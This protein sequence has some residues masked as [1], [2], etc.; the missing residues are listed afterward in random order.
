MSDEVEKRIEAAA[1]SAQ[2][3]KDTAEFL[4]SLKPGD[5]LMKSR[6]NPEAWIMR[7]KAQAAAVRGDIPTYECPHPV[8]YLRQFVD[9]DPTVGRTGRTVN[10][11]E[12]SCGCILWM[13]DPWLKAASDG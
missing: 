10:L 2:R 1:A 12:C 3:Q 9:E 4:A 11:F 5:E 8:Q 6:S 13:V 7:D